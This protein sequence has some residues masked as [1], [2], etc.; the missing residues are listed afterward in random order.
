MNLWRGAEHRGGHKDQSQLEAGKAN[1]V[2]DVHHNEQDTT[3]AP[4]TP[5]AKVPGVSGDTRRASG[6]SAQR[7]LAQPST[8]RGISHFVPP[9]RAVEATR[10]ALRGQHAPTVAEGCYGNATWQLKCE[11]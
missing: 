9:D 2:L 3:T 5:A 4:E 6:L 10:S 11:K 7:Y 8:G 1:E